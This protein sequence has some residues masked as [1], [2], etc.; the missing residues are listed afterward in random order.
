V[1]ADKGYDS[2]GLRE[3]IAARGA[4]AVIAAVQTQSK[5]HASS[6]LLQASMT[7]ALGFVRHLI[8]MTRC[9]LIIFTAGALRVHRSRLH[10]QAPPHGL[11]FYRVE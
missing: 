4:E 3:A 9:S 5:E 11:C 6:Y 7:S 10:A 2:N 8:A 1:L